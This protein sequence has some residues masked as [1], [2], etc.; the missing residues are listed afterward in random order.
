MLSPM[1]SP[2]R[3]PNATAA[4]YACPA[5]GKPSTFRSRI[6]GFDLYRCNQCG[7]TFVP[8][9][10]LSTVDYNTLYSEGGGYDAKLRNADLLDSG[11]NPLPRARRTVIEKL[12][13]SPPAKALE[14]GCGVGDFLHALEALGTTKC[15]GTEISS[16]AAERARKVVKAPIAIAPFDA[17]VFPD[18]T[19]DAIFMWEVIEHVTDLRPLFTEINRRIGPGGQLFLSTP[20][21]GL[22]LVWEDVPRDPRATP[23]VHVTFWNKRALE[24]FLRDIGFSRVRVTGASFPRNAVRRAG[25]GRLAE[26]RAAVKAKLFHSHRLT[27][28][29]EAVK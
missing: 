5:D 11:K 23:P 16:N 24:S 22:P 8:P 7:L 13:T 26:L 20:N 12:R 4:G 15:F 25:G 2:S 6:N 10:D 21:Y 9:Q 17:T 18:E 14:I 29:A 1:T 27:L 19:F 3:P 28:I